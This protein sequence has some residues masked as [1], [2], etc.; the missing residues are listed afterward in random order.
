MALVG[1]GGKDILSSNLVATQ[2]LFNV[3][4]LPYFHREWCAYN[5]TTIA[6][7]GSSLM[8]GKQVLGEGLLPMQR[9]LESIIGTKIFQMLL[10]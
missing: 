8:C 6:A 4:I 9:L 2:W 3:N 5:V 10:A 7:V 1:V